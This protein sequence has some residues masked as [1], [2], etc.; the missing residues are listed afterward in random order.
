MVGGSTAG[1]WRQRYRP[2]VAVHS[3]QY[4]DY[5]DKC[6]LIQEDISRKQAIRKR[7]YS[8]GNATEEELQLN[9]ET[10]EALHEEKR[11]HATDAANA[12]DFY[13]K[14]IQ[15]CQESWTEIQNLLSIPVTARTVQENAQL[16]TLKHTFTL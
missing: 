5:C 7:L 12:R 11:Q 10:I 13:K 1:G 4:T 14:S 8:S 2:K 3:T 16:A 9:E 6:K 15:K